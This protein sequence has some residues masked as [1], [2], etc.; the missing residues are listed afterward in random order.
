MFMLRLEYENRLRLDFGFYSLEEAVT[1]RQRIGAAKDGAMVPIQDDH[2]HDAMVRTAGL[3]AVM[4][5]DVAAE[6]D[7][8]VRFQHAMDGVRREVIAELAPQNFA[9]PA[10]YAETARQAPARTPFAS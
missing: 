9:D 2:G 4:L 10:P 6:T 8:A 3:Q 5:T 1:V 7:G